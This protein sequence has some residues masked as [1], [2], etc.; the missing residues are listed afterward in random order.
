MDLGHVGCLGPVGT[1]NECSCPVDSGHGCPA[2]V[3]Y[4]N[5]LDLRAAGHIDCT[6][7]RV[8]TRLVVATL[9]DAA[10]YSPELEANI[11]PVRAQE[12]H[13]G[14]VEADSPDLDHIA[15]QEPDGVA[16]QRDCRGTGH[17]DLE[18]TGCRGWTS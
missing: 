8:D 15:G 5:T 1:A 6:A 10:D 7:G 3:D 2:R 17:L 4:H 16:H 14:A 9:I 18:D 11:P 13:I 12:S